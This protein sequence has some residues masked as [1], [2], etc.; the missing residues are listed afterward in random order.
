MTP[1]LSLRRDTNGLS[2]PSAASAPDPPQTHTQPEG[3]ATATASS[4]ETSFPLPHPL[5]SYL[6][7]TP[8]PA[9]VLSREI[10][11]RAPAHTGGRCTCRSLGLIHW[12][13][14]LPPPFARSPLFLS[15][16][17]YFPAFSFLASLSPLIH[18]S[19]SGSRCFNLCA[20]LYSRYK[21]DR[22]LNVIIRRD[23]PFFLSGP[24]YVL[25][26][27]RSLTCKRRIYGLSSIS[28]R[29]KDM[30]VLAERSA[31]LSGAFGGSTPWGPLPR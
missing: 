7:S 18:P 31:C 10:T 30:C 4:R 25:A 6:G 19:K 26:F 23:R 12:L 13:L 20:I 16:R 22:V 17:L 15:L 1:A 29:G 14:E 27:T 3:S 28:V 24:W 9:T 11:R 2:K 8:G 21:L 5:P